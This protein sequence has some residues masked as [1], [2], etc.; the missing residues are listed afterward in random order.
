MSLDW[1][2]SE[3]ANFKE[4]CWDDVPAELQRHHGKRKLN[5]DTEMC[6][7]GAMFLGL[8]GI[9]ANNVDEW[10]WRSEFCRRLNIGWMQQFEDDEDGKS[11]VVY[12]YPTAQAVT[13]HIGLR[14]NVSNESRTKWRNR[15]IKSLEREVT[16]NA[17]EVLEQ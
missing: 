14:T 9:R 2:V 7:W 15:I 17:K 13:D 5:S 3:V 8:S 6:V 4:R 12:C 10:I 11:R 1:S 16:L